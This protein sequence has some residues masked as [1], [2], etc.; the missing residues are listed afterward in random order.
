MIFFTEKEGFID[1]HTINFN[2]VKN[3]LDLK[4]IQDNN[5]KNC[6]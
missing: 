5:K 3:D 4:S 6:K 1:G 2:L